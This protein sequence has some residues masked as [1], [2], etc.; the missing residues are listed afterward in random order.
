[1]DPASLAIMLHNLVPLLGM[2]AVCGVPIGIVWVVNSHNLRMRELD[3]EERAMLPR[4]AETRL[5]ALEQRLRAIEGALDVA[6]PSSLEQRAGLLEGPAS[7]APALPGGA[8]LK[9]R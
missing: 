4:T 9:Q 3:L 7:S 8:R 2:L 1:M 6:Q 5:A